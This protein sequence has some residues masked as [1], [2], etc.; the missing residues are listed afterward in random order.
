MSQSTRLKILMLL[1][2]N[3]LCACE[4]EYILGITQSA[5]SQHM[6][7]LKEANLVKEFR[8]GQWVFYALNE[9]CLKEAGEKL[10]I[11]ASGLMSN[12]GIEREIEKLEYLKEHPIINCDRPAIF[13]K[14]L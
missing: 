1:S 9:E 5:V 8:E 2:N 10:K 12:E 14:R 6:R 7:I 13:K 4:L 3:V 11:I